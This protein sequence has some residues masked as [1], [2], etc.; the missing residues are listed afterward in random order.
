[1]QP[2]AHP[3]GSRL[4]RGECPDDAVRSARGHR[5]AHPYN[6]PRI[7]RRIIDGRRVRGGGFGPS[8]GADGG[9]GAD[10]RAGT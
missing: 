6:P 1:M 5:P 2:A 7:W 9:V 4:N 8:D 3:L 10:G